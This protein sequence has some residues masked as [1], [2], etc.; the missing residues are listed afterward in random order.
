M[1]IKTPRGLQEWI[2]TPSLWAAHPVHQV[3][4]DKTNQEA[5]CQLW[6]FK[7]EALSS[8]AYT[9]DSRSLEERA[10]L[11]EASSEDAGTFSPHWQAK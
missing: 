3:R 11:E 7:A 10:D 9:P 4:D 2:Y 1:G 8:K 5:K 6:D